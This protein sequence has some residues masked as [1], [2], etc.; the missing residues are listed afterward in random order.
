MQLR[1]V[2]ELCPKKLEKMPD[3]EEFHDRYEARMVTE[4]L[5]WDD[6]TGMQLDR[7]MVKEAR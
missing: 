2:M 5:A 3:I 6:L 1:A 4:T 7:G